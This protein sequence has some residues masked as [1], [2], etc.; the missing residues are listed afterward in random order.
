[1]FTTFF[2]DDLRAEYDGRVLDREERAAKAAQLQKAMIAAGLWHSPRWVLDVGCGSGLTLAA[3]DAPGARR[4]GCDIRLEPFLKAGIDGALVTLV[5][6]D[7]CLLPF[8]GN[9]FDL[10]ICLAVIEESPDWR[11]M[12]EA[13]AE[14]TA[15]G[16]ML[17]IT[18]TNGKSLVPL[19]TLAKKLGV[20]VKESSWQYARS[21]LRFVPFSASDGFRLVGL[22]GWRHVDVTPYL[23][24]ARYPLLRVVPLAILSWLITNI[25]SSFGYAWHKPIGLES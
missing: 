2:S 19:Y 17:Y 16:G 8:R 15:P 3:L 7:A 1:M 14:C 21:S 20:Y 4:I 6:G 18:M 12:I 24:R 10:V 25:S 5:Q 13:M 22:R 11:A 9:C 23:A